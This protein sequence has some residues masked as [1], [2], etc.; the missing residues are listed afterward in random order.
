MFLVYLRVYT[1]VNKV[2]DVGSDVPKHVALYCMVLGCFVSRNILFLFQQE[3]RSCEQGDS[4]EICSSH[5]SVYDCSYLAG[6][7]ATLH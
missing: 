4:P 3:E 1:S 2:S 5:G 7:D 6:R